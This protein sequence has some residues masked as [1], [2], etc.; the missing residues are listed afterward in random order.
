MANASLEIREFPDTLIDLTDGV[1]TVTITGLTGLTDRPRD[2]TVEESA[3]GVVS[4]NPPTASTTRKEYL[5]LI[6]LRAIEIGLDGDYSLIEDESANNATVFSKHQHL[7]AQVT[8]IVSRALM[9]L[10]PPS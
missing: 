9:L 8:R 2:I 3:Y 5:P 10:D 6:L 1:Y 4:A 7:L